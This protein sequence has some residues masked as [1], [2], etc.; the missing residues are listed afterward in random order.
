MDDIMDFAN[1]HVIPHWPFFTWFIVAALFGEI[2]K[3]TLWTKENAIKKQPH[4]FWWWARKSMAAHP[5]LV[6]VL[7]GIF[8]RDPE[9]GVDKLVESMGYFALAGALS[10]WGFEF[11]KGLFKKKAD[12]D[13]D[14]PGFSEP[15]PG[16]K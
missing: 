13:I 16:D 11:L 5:V 7:I 4:W 8:W 14:L 9:E 2:F 10:V 12:V 1:A 3:R 15:P 6:G